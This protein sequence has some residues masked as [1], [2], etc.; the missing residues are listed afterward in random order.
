M[1]VSGGVWRCVCA[2]R[3][4][5]LLGW[6]SMLSLIHCVLQQHS[7]KLAKVMIAN[8]GIKMWKDDKQGVAAIQRC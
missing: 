6:M 5:C 4:L 2:I 3:L 8:K 7:R 1:E